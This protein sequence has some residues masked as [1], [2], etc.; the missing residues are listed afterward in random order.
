MSIVVVAGT[1]PE[2]D[3]RARAKVLRWFYV[4][5]AFFGLAVLGCALVLVSVV[6]A[7]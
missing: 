2:R 7:R 3:E 5:A 4:G 1:R 6:R